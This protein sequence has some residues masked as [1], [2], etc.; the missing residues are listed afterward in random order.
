MRPGRKR[1]IDPVRAKA[2]RDLGWSWQRIA[3]KFSHEQ[4]RHPRYT[5]SA[6]KNAVIRNERNERSYIKGVGVYVEEPISNSRRSD[7]SDYE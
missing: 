2:M 6:A 1:G 7:R 5:S 4:N 3:D